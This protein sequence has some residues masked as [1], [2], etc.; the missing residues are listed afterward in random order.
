MGGFRGF[1]GF[2]LLAGPISTC[3]KT[4]YGT[5]HVTNIT[6]AAFLI[7]PEK[8]R[9]LSRSRREPFR[10]AGE[11]NDSDAEKRLPR[12]QCVPPLA[13]AAYEVRNLSRC[14]RA[15]LTLLPLRIYT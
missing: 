6:M 9:G 3:P 13:I 14:H 12:P 4:V 8:S 15:Q 2:R 10:K 5:E 11:K 1:R 7:F